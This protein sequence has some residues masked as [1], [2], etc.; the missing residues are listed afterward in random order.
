MVPSTLG[1]PLACVKKIII[2]RPGYFLTGPK[3]STITDIGHFSFVLH[4]DFR[5]DKEKKQS[6]T[7]GQNYN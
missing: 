6:F 2:K 5:Y 1:H 4:H 3:T 7:S